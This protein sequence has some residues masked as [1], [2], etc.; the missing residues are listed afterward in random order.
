MAK[1]KKS[2]KNNLFRK[3][4]SNDIVLVTG[5]TSSGK[6][7]LAPIVSS[8]RSEKI[9]F[10]FILEQ[11]PILQYMGK[12]S[13]DTA[14]Y[15]IDTIDLMLYDN[16]IGRDVNFRFSDETS[17]WKTSNPKR[18]FLKDYLNEGKEAFENL[19]NNSSLSVLA[20]H[21]SVWHSKVYFEAY[22]SIKML[23]CKEILS[24]L[25]IDGLKKG[26]VLNF[27]MALKIGF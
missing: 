25:L 18:V 4:L 22:P 2:K 24:I 10:N 17:V 1:I 12:I 20:T 16:I 27:I 11:Y 21:N 5:F 23:H 7:M 3:N 26:L 13:V 15:L 6:S 9:M 8:K 19:Q 14:K